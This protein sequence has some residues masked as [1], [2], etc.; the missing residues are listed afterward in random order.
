MFSMSFFFR[1]R[2]IR[3]WTELFPTAVAERLTEE[4]GRL[5][6]RN[7]RRK[8]KIAR[9]RST[10]AAAT[11][12]TPIEPLA[13]SSVS[14]NAGPR[15]NF[16]SIQIQ[17]FI[18]GGNFRSTTAARTLGFTEAACRQARIGTSPIC[19]SSS[20]ATQPGENNPSH[21]FVPNEIGGSS[22]FLLSSVCR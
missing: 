11:A 3:C 21:T 19:G 22:S 16:G 5:I 14:G 8:I 9:S 7:E 6:S 13:N 10:A 15:A 4:A 20:P 1:V 12:A 18:G 17:S 2:S